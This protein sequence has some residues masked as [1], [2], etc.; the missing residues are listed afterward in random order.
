MAR[1][2]LQEAWQSQPWPAIDTDQLVREV[3]RGQQQFAATIFWRDVRE[4]G[5]SLLLLPVWVAM[6][7]VLGLPWTW[8]LEM[9]AL[10]WVAVFMTADRMRQRRR[11]AGP[12]DTLIRGVECSLA[13]VEH[14]IWLLRNVVWWYLLPLGIPMLAFLGQTFW[15]ASR[16]D[17][18]QATI[19]TF[20]VTVVVGGV[21]AWVYWLNQKAVRAVLEPRRQ[22][23]AAMLKSLSDEPLSTD[24]N[25]NAT[26]DTSN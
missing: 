13:A 22:E 18:W 17:V 7:V 15:P 10:L 19:A 8:Y 1:D 14:Q 4:V 26:G 20:F 11:R 9:P 25:R 6:G 23:L 16:R 2:P 5:V 24:T 12:G 3:R 21:L